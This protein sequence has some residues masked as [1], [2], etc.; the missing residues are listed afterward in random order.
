MEDISLRKYEAIGE[1]DL[2]SNES[3]YMSSPQFVRS[4]TTLCETVLQSENKEDTLLKGLDKI[5]E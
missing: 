5:N 4:L 2:I 3:G 1:S